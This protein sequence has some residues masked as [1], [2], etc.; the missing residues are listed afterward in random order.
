MGR[1]LEDL[2]EGLRT[3][4]EEK[5]EDER[6]S[7]EEELARKVK[8]FRRRRW[9]VRWRRARLCKVAVERRFCWVR[10]VR[11]GTE[12][13][14]A[15]SRLEELQALVGR[16]GMRIIRREEERRWEELKREWQWRRRR[17]NPTH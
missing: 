7:A 3:L 12:W 16:E 6:R 4:L 1:N 17:L 5:V 9:L 14:E 10:A 2:V 8:E 13:R 11:R 15:W